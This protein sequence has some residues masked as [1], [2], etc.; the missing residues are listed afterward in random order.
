MTNPRNLQF[1]FCLTCVWSCVLLAAEE[2]NLKAPILQFEESQED[3]Q[4]PT[5]EAMNWA[6]ATGQ[7]ITC[8]VSL[9]PKAE[10]TLLSFGVTGKPGFDDHVMTLDLSEGQKRFLAAWQRERRRNNDRTVGA[11]SCLSKSIRLESR[12]CYMP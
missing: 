6:K 7:R 11:R 2:P 3:V 5:F 12:S 8:A 4:P 1:A 9:T 10:T